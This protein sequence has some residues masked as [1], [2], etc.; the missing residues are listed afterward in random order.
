MLSIAEPWES[1]MTTNGRPLLTY[2]FAN[3]Q[4]LFLE[5]LRTG[6]SQQIDRE[7]A[8]VSRAFAEDEADPFGALSRF[9]VRRAGRQAESE[10]LQGEFWLYALRNPEA[11]DV[12][13]GKPREEVD[14]IQPAIARAMAETGTAPGITPGEMTTVALTLF[15]GLARRR[16]IDE[17]SVPGDLYARVLRRLFAPGE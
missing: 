12:V 14:G 7:V 4:E 15:Q 17:A 10:P 16:R 3:K 2:H 8:A 13:A 9:L 1:P 11:M 6:W 5:L